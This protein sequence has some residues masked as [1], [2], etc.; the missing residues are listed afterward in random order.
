MYHYAIQDLIVNMV[1][2]GIRRW[3]RETYAGNASGGI[4][5]VDESKMP[6]I[7]LQTIFHVMNRMA[8]PNAALQVRWAKLLEQQ[9]FA[10]ASTLWA[11]S[12]SLIK[13][14]ILAFYHKVFAMRKFRYVLYAECAL[15]GGILLFSII[16]PFV[17]CTPFNYTWNKTIEGH[18]MPFM[19]FY[20][21]VAAVNTFV[22]LSIFCLPL[23]I[24]WKLNMAKEK[25]MALS[26]VFL[27]GLM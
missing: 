3:R 20:L 4:F 25:K 8:F 2:S 9:I 16:V 7:P 23:P 6:I 27:L 10:G 5:D 1:V 22:D 14:S 11:L 26:A 18:C 12:A 13:L 19:S 24:L 21:P 15:I 17:L